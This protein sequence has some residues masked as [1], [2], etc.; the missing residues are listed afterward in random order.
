MKISSKYSDNRNISNI[1]YQENA[2]RNII[3][4]RNIKFKLTE[5]CALAEGVIESGE[6]ENEEKILALL[7]IAK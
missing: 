3:A 4:L 5:A 7:F 2:N 6:N 1:K